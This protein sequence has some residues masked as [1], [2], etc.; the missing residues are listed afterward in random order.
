LATNSGWLWYSTSRC[1]SL[2][3]TT[4]YISWSQSLD[5]SIAFLIRPRFLL[6][7]VVCLALSSWIL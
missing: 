6:Q 2:S 1:F 4:R 3:N 7:K 5:N